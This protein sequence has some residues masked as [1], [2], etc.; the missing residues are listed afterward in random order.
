MSNRAFW[1]DVIIVQNVQNINI[2][3]TDTVGNAGCVLLGQEHSMTSN[4]EATIFSTWSTAV[5]VKGLSALYSRR[6][7]LCRD[8]V[9]CLFIRVKVSISRAVWARSVWT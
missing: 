8:G 2:D 9:V 3:V 5:V 6:L 1:F 7:R 4:K